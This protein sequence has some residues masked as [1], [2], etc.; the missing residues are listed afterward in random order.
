MKEKRFK[1]ELDEALITDTQKQLIGRYWNYDEENKKFV[2]KAKT[3]FQDN[4]MS[5]AANLSLINSLSTMRMA[6][7][8]KVCLNEFWLPVYSRTQ[9]IYNITCHIDIPKYFTCEKCRILL[10]EEQ[11]A[12]VEKERAKIVEQ[13]RE[14]YEQQ[15][16]K[17]L[18]GFEFKVLI[19]T[20]KNNNYN[21]TLKYY[22]NQ[23]SHGA[24]IKTLDKLDTLNLVQINQESMSE[25]YREILFVK[26]TQEIL[27]SI[28]PFD[29][30][31]KETVL[32]E[33]LDSSDAD[34][35]F[36]NEL[37]FFLYPNHD[38]SYLSPDFSTL[39]EIKEDIVLKKGTTF[40][41][42]GWIKKNGR[43]NVSIVPTSEIEANTRSISME[44]VPKEIGDLMN[45]HFYKLK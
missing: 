10:K 30:N 28:L 17:S 3:V 14:A 25:W 41:A 45:L 4:D 33:N 22:G 9:F 38:K 2:D 31:K 43:I 8:C 15:R 20:L 7:L 16:Y 24:F 37:K 6:K 5:L 27:S 13:I 11:L 44:K 40:S 23:G 32:P 35:N 19:N 21:T 39:I 12:K 29:P 26:E 42:G 18:T 34:L 36:A 1:L